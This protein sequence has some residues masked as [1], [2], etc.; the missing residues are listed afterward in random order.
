MKTKNLIL[1]LLLTLLF[2]F[3]ANAQYQ[4]SIPRAQ[5]RNCPEIPSFVD[6]DNMDDIEYLLKIIV[7]NKK[8]MPNRNQ[9]FDANCIVRILGE[10]GMTQLDRVSISTYMLRIR[11][12]DELQQ[13]VPI[14]THV[15]N[16]KI[17]EL[18]VREYYKGRR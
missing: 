2:A 15:D 12:S 4:D 9:F 1:M 16:G 7:C 3:Q 18:H 5:R 6:I 17:R 10:D 8:D 14:T 13:V 11:T